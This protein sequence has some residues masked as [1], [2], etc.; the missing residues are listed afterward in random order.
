V[1]RPHR[2]E[3]GPFVLNPL[4]HLLE[5][6]NS[7]DGVGNVAAG[8]VEGLGLF[9]GKGPF[10]LIVQGIQDEKAPVGKSLLQMLTQPSAHLSPARPS[11]SQGRIVLESLPQL[12]PLLGR[13]GF[14]K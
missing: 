12:R 4:H 5:C 1:L 6:W 10:P 11:L 7:V 2:L 8:R 3:V 13:K 9:R 14:F